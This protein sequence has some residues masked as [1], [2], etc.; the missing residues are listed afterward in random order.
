MK[1][2][3]RA[4]KNNIIPRIIFICSFKI[5]KNKSILMLGDSREKLEFFDPVGVCFDGTIPPSI[6]NA[7]LL[8]IECL[9][10]ELAYLVD[11]IH[12]VTTCMGSREFF[13]T[14]SEIKTFFY[15]LANLK[16]VNTVAS[17]DIN[18]ESSYSNRKNLYLN[19]VLLYLEAVNIN[20][21]RTLKCNHKKNY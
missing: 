1:K 10:H 6:L 16:K 4:N 12:Y 8:F 3:D 17:F 5:T 15:H 14:S 18:S 19:N 2:N 21:L 13:F 11:F 7:E 9:N 20:E